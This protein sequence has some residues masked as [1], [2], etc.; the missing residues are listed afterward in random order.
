MRK[1]V[2][3]RSHWPLGRFSF[4][5]ASAR[6][7]ETKRL[8][9]GGKTEWTAQTGGAATS[10]SHSQC[11]RLQPFQTRPTTCEKMKRVF[12]WVTAAA[13]R[14]APAGNVC[15]RVGRNSRPL[16]R[17]RSVHYCVLFFFFFSSTRERNAFF[18]GATIPFNLRHRG[19]SEISLFLN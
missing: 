3:F 18:A 1:W 8:P 15:T 12:V 19:D 10:P 6:T 14:R 7:S 5:L 11:I 9:A 17:N 2:S 16:V 4:S 13:A